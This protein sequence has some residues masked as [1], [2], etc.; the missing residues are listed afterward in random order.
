MNEIIIIFS[1]QMS[2]KRD[3]D[4]V[5][6]ED[7]ELVLKNLVSTD[8][9]DI[10]QVLKKLLKRAEE[11]KEDVD[12][13]KDTITERDINTALSAV[14]LIIGDIIRDGEV[15]VIDENPEVCKFQMFIDYPFSVTS[16][17]L[18]K[19]AD[20]T[21]VCTV[22]C[23]QKDFN[24]MIITLTYTKDRKLFLYYKQNEEATTERRVRVKQEKRPDTIAES[25]MDQIESQVDIL[26]EGPDNMQVTTRNIEKDFTMVTFSVLVKGP[27][28]QEKIAAIATHKMIRSVSIIASFN[29]TN[30]RIE[31]VTLKSVPKKKPSGLT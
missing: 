22:E 11:M 23:D 18:A 15:L 19:L 3:R 24:E 7:E 21:N 30:L 5:E 4:E 28:R 16:A 26:Y 13:N 10:V 31:L 27:I 25:I 14:K 6:K 9:K 12:Q 20:I 17:D 8:N 2:R 29:T 1:L